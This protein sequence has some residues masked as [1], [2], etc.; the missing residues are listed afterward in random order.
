MPERQ[1]NQR[2]PPLPSPEPDESGTEL[3]RRA[4]AGDD[5]S[6]DE[7]ARRHTGPLRR[8]LVGRGVAEAVAD[9]LV[10]ETLIRAHSSISRYDS[11]YAFSTW[12]Y[13]IAARLAISLH[14]RAAREE[15][16]Q[17]EFAQEQETVLDNSGWVIPEDAAREI[18]ETAERVLTPDQFEILRLRYVEN[19]ATAEIARVLGKSRVSVRVSLHRARAIL[20][21]SLAGGSERR[22]EG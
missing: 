1:K 5:A 22:H 3:A 20:A 17:R 21:G 9:D 2:T 7:L 13:S 8:F 18:W 11:R 4:A 19:M 14:R 16:A 6:F 12:L 10:Q 15:E